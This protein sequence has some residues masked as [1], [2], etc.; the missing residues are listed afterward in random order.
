MSTF[1]FLDAYLSALP[2]VLDLD[3]IKSAGVRIGADPLGGASVGYWG[4][5]ADRFG[6]DLTV[7]NPDVDKTFGFMTLDWDGKIRMDCSSPYAMASLLGRQGD[8]DVATGNDTDAD[9]H[10][11]ITPDGGLMN[12]NQY[13]AVAIQYLYTHRPSWSRD[14]AIGKTLVSSSTSLRRSCAA[15]RSIIDE[16]H[17]RLPDRGVA[18]PPTAGACRG[19]GW[20]RPGS[21][22]GSSTRRRA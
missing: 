12:P 13:L 15:T 2:Q 17:Q 9:R 11:I 10:G 14:A 19:T 7:V 5:I 4:E 8:F 21:G 6:L 18:R 20:R 16:L 22:W 1:D 3:A